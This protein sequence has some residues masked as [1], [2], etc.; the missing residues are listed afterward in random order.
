MAAPLVSFRD[1]VDAKIT[2]LERR[3][4]EL[5]TLRSAA[6]ESARL[7]MNERL[8]TMNELRGSLNDM[9]NR[10]ATRE[11]LDAH[12]VAMEIRIEAVQEKVGDVRVQVAVAAALVSLLVSLVVM[13]VSQWLLK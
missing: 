8:A 7:S 9:A 12:R 4:T 6:V 5:D 3:V 11:Q 10:A 1:Y 13:A 2:A